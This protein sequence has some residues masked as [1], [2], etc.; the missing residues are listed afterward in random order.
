MAKTQYHLEGS[1]NRKKSTL[2]TFWTKIFS[3]Q[4]CHLGPY[5]GSKMEISAK[6]DPMGRF[7]ILVPQPYLAIL[8]AP[9]ALLQYST[10][11]GPI[12]AK[13]GQKSKIF[14]VSKWVIYGSET[15][16]YGPQEV[17]RG[18]RNPLGSRVTLGGSPSPGIPPPKTG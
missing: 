5:G 16:K 2:S 12:E 6:T 1:K 9:K 14:E 18:R 13:I 11:R 4:K 17:L 3:T 7:S 15:S 8:G 10:E